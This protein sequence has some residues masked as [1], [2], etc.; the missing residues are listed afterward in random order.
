MKHLTLL[1]T[2]LFFTSVLNAQQPQLTVLTSGTKTSIRGLSVVSDSVIWVSGSNGMV[3]VTT[4]AGATWQWHQVNGFEKTDFRDIHA[5]DHRLAVIMGIAEPAYILKT[6][7]GGNSWSITYKNETKGMFL[8]A[9]DFNGSNG[10]VVG[11]PI[12]GK[13]FIATTND[14]GRSWSAIPDA[15]K[16]L[17]DEGEACFAASGTNIKLVAADLFYLVSGGKTSHLFVNNMKGKLPLLQ[18]KESTG[19]NSIA[20]FGAKRKIVVGGDFADD[21]NTTGNCAYS[22]NSKKWKQCK[23][24]PSG[25][26]SCV[27]FMNK[28]TA[29]ACGTSGVDITYNGGKTWKQISTE[30]FHVCGT[31]RTGKVLYLAGSNGRIAKLNL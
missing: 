24:P 4:D 30:S 23:V 29:I 25:Y 27:T 5:F 22:T 31:T 3:A 18:G 13:F 1:Y 15:S 12:D 16:P 28:K 7:N 9:M 14:H 10:I 17:A 20:M 21:K 8:D 26:R 6:D 2:V 19:A 11:D